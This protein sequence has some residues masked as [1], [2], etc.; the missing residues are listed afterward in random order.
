MEEKESITA[1]R[2]RLKRIQAKLSQQHSEDSEL[3]KIFTETE[4]MLDELIQQERIEA[5]RRGLSPE[6]LA[7]A[8]KGEQT[9]GLNL[10]EAAASRPAKGKGG[11]DTQ[12][13][14]PLVRALVLTG[15]CFVL[16][17]RGEI[18]G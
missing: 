17:S 3:W 14:S 11:H 10:A 5:A 16:C 12:P 18:G 7:S 2:R 8:V 9:T 13:L 15:V 6:E 4:E 1:L